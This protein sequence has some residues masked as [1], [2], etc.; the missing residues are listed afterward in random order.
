MSTKTTV[1][2]SEDVD[3]RVRAVDTESG[4]A[5]EGDSV[6]EALIELART[7]ADVRDDVAALTELMEARLADADP[8]TAEFIELARGTRARFEERGSR[9]R[10]STGPSNG[11][12][13][14]S[15]RHERPR[16]RNRVR[17]ESLAVP[18]GR[19]RRGCRA[20]HVRGR[21]R[22]VRARSRV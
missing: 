10:T 14:G 20:G 8:A 12:A 22:G 18:G 11:P 15:I 6:P 1:E 21:P 19:L 5:G 17:G 3:G 9:R 13:P 16:L 7:L 4:A 2:V